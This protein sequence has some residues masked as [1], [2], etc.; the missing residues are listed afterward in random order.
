M[1]SPISQTGVPD[2]NKFKILKRGSV[3]IPGTVSPPASSSGHNTV[4]VTHNFGFNPMFLAYA[5]VP[6]IDWWGTQLYNQVIPVPM[7]FN[8]SSSLGNAGNYYYVIGIA[9]KTALTFY[10]NWYTHAAP[11]NTDIPPIPIRYVLFELSASLT[12]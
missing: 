4:V 3:T 1:S 12:I 10:N 7:G 2:F 6:K 11:N 5:Y 9:T 8:E